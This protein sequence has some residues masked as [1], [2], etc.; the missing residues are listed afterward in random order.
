[1]QTLPTHDGKPILH[2]DSDPVIYDDAGAWSFDEQTMVQSQDGAM[3][4]E[5][6]PDRPLGAPLCYSTTS[7]CLRVCVREL[8][9][10]LMVNVL[11]FH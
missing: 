8:V 11:Q 1:M 5:T 3:K 6:V 9:G 4:T 10:I 2:L 7:R